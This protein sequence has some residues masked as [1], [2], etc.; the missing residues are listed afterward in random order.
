M[1]QTYAIIFAAPLLITHPRDPDPRRDRRLAPLGRGRV[2]LLGVIVVLRPGSTALTAGHA[3][4]MG[5][6]VF[7]AIAAVIVRKIGHEERSAVLLL[8]P[9]MANFVIMGCAMPFVYHA[10]AGAPPRRHRADGAP[11]LRRRRSATSP[12]TAPAARSSWRRC[13][14]RR[15]SGRSLY[16][17]VFFGETPTA[18]PA[19]APRSSSPAASTSSSAR[20]AA[21]RS[22]TR[23]VLRTETRYVMGTSR[24]SSLPPHPAACGARRHGPGAGRQ[25]AR[26]DVRRRRSGPSARLTPALAHCGVTSG[27]YRSVAQPGSAPAS[28]AGGRRFES[29]HSDQPPRN[30]ARLPGAAAA[31]GE[32]QPDVAADRTPGDPWLSIVV[33]LKNE[34]ENV[35]F[36]TE[37]IA[38][39]CAD[40]GPYE[41][42]LR[43]RRLDRRHRR[44]ACSRCA[45]AY[46]DA[47]PGAARGQ[48]RPVGGDPQRRRLRP[49]RG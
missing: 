24:A 1:A 42:D 23:P 5:A 44:R 12:P 25:G 13:S 8:Y 22:R 11:R 4:A 26:D 6:A 49:R 32:G 17:F 10:D 9:M 16:G 21:T 48:R 35:A 46:P 33:P 28:G 43:R 38:A 27:R 3:A 19:S 30:R 45:S 36:V 34:A 2:G 31:R 15:S 7:S 37:A 41:V 47:A 29:S 39:A 40:L 20:T 14:I 18:P